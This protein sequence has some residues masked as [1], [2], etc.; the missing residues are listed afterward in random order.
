MDNSNDV[1]LDR[2]ELEEMIVSLNN[3]IKNYLQLLKQKS[4]E[5]ILNGSILVAQKIINQI[6]PIEGEFKKMDASHDSFLSVLRNNKFIDSKKNDSIDI[7]KNNLENIDM[8]EMD[9]TPTELYR[10]PILKSL[11]YLGGT[12]KLSDVASFIEKEMKNKFKPA[13]QEKGTNGFGKLWI[14]MVN[15]EKENMINEGLISEDNKTEQWEIIQ[16]GINYL[17]QYAN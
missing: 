17:A 7:K 15:S 14:E 3:K 12:A 4:S 13:D 10:I 2:T 11:I 1:S 5:E 9:F 8:S 16:K 6:L